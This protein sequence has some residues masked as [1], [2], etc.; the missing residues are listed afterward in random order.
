[1]KN[2]ILV[3][4]GHQ[5]VNDHIPAILM[6]ND[7]KIAAIVDSK[8]EIARRYS[9]EYDVDFFINT[10]EIK[11]FSRY[12]FAIIAVPHNQ[13]LP[14]LDTFAKNGIPVLKEKPIAMNS[15]EAQKILKIF[16]E[17][18]T[19]L[20]ICVQRRFSKFYDL[21]RE[22]TKRI[23][24][25]YSINA[26]Y[27]MN[28]RKLSGWRNDIKIAGGA[29]VIDMGYHIID[30]LSDIFGRPD[31]VYA[32]LNHQSLGK[33][34]TTDDGAKILM[35][36][37]DGKI[38]TNVFMS[39]T[40]YK[41]SEVIEIMGCDG[42]IIIDGREVILLDKSGNEIEKHSFMDKKHEISE[43]LD[44]FIKNMSSGFCEDIL[45]RGQIL[46]INIIDGIY[47]SANTEKV[48]KI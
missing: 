42:T 34:Y 39:S 37:N 23:G 13:Y 35:A 44:Y 20:Q 9:E 46:N 11:D 4:L 6:R 29:A 26:K 28:F 40:Y 36:Y 48:V 31:K 14:I 33:D 32:Q 19:Y 8:T 47:R 41:K 27:T 38:N 22:M 2:V 1:M 25:I 5:M 45:L 7:I 30:I 16:S 15:N 18:D 21:V 17:N 12:D 3:G 10:N 24:R 43:Q